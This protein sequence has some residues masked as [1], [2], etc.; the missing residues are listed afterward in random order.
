MDEKK[1]NIWTI[2]FTVLKY[3]A[4]AALGALGGYGVTAL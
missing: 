1:K 4:T 2:V 3:I